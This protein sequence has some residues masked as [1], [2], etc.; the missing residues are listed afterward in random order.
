M[1]LQVKLM[2]T[3][4][5]LLQNITARN[6]HAQLAFFAV[7]LLAIADFVD[8]TENIKNG[9]WYTFDLTFTV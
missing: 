4:Y 9:M 3:T 8:D 1:D 5:S 6:S 7:F 2:A